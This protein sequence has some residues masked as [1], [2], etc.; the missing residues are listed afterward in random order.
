MVE[1]SSHVVTVAEVHVFVCC[2]VCRDV[3][4]CCNGLSECSAFVKELE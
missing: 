4:L 3:I 2:N 1:V